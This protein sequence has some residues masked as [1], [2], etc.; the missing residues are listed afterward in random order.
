MEISFGESVHGRLEPG[1][2]N[3][4]N[5]WRRAIRIELTGHPSQG[6]P[7][8]FEDRGRH[9]HGKARQARTA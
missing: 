5:K 9:Q 6:T 7:T 2:R 3:F 4:Q 1:K 8:G